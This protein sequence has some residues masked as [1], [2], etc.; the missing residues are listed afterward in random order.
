MQAFPRRLDY[1]DSRS[2]TSTLG[3]VSERQPDGAEESETPLNGNNRTHALRNSSLTKSTEMQQ[4]PEQ[5]PLIKQN[6]DLDY[7]SNDDES[8]KPDE[9][10]V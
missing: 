9:M 5:E 7:P 8:F 6:R 10:K 2:R 1:S 3:S 4:I